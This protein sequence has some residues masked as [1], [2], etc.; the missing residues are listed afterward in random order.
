MDLVELI[1]AGADVWAITDSKIVSSVNS[2]DGGIDGNGYGGGDGEGAGDGL[3]S[4][5]GWEE[6][7][8]SF[9]KG[10]CGISN[11]DRITTPGR[12]NGRGGGGDPVFRL[13]DLEE[14]TEYGWTWSS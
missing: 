12:G 8:D 1:L 11:I 7:G 3:G 2:G 9:A 13:D 14:N 10:R 6:W 4:F 5:H